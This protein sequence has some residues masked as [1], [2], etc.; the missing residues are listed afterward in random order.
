MN[1]DIIIRDSHSPSEYYEQVQPVPSV[2]EVRVLADEAHRDDL[3]E[4]L[5]GEERK[6]EVIQGFEDEAAPGVTRD[7]DAWFEH[8]QRDTVENDDRH[9]DPFKPCI[10]NNRL[11][12]NPLIYAETGQVVRIMHI[13]FNLYPERMR[14]FY[15]TTQYLYIVWKSSFKLFSYYINIEAIGIW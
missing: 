14:S 11:R 4:H 5:E 2:S 7:V 12:K 15:K 13:F 6:D 8:A 1:S 9:T 3:N 10:D